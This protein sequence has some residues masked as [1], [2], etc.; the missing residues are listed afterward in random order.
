MGTIGEHV[1]A[2]GTQ[3]VVL[4]RMLVRGIEPA[5][6]ARAIGAPEGHAVAANHPAFVYGHLGLYPQRI[7][8]LMG[9]EPDAVAP[10]DGYEALFSARAAC[11]DDPDGAVY[12]AM[13]EIV[14]VFTRGYEVLLGRIGDVDDAVFRRPLPEGSGYRRI[15]PDVGVAVSFLLTSHLM[16]HL[17]QVST[18]RRCFGLQSAM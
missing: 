1:A 10:P 16:F 17:G 13:D 5:Q 18:W 12:P 14:G 8:D 15:A 11:V 6:F 7:F 4:G 3:G 9:F 2:V